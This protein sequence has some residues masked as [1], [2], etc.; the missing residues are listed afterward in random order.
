MCGP[1]WRV[2]TPSRLFVFHRRGE[3]VEPPQDS[4]TGL[5]AL[6]ET[7]GAVR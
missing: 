2:M 3:A 6:V 5:S 1:R 4:A 7:V